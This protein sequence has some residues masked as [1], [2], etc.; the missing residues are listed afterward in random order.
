MNVHPCLYYGQSY[1]LNVHNK[2]FATSLQS[3]AQMFIAHNFA[4]SE[5]RWFFLNKDSRGISQY[6]LVSYMS[7]SLWYKTLTIECPHI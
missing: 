3:H 2:D 6:L 1:L 5:H 7:A 4:V